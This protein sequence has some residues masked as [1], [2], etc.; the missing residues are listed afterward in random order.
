[1]SFIKK[2]TEDHL[3]D[4]GRGR[5]NQIGFCEG[6]RT[7]FNL[8]VLQYLV[9]RALGRKERLFVIAI[10]FKKAF[11][12]VDRIKLIDTMEE[13]K[14][15][16]SVVDLVARLFSEDRTELTLGDRKEEIRVNSGIKQ[17]CPFSTTLFKIVT[18]MI[19]KELEEKG[20]SNDVDGE[21]ISS[22]WFA[23]DSMLFAKTK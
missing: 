23:D 17:G 8:F 21:N 20:I 19:I 4:S 6:G 15:N 14:I 2:K 22:L 12:S 16:A 13:M 9:G 10:D 7:E 5:V 18:Y 1:M 11:D 3:K